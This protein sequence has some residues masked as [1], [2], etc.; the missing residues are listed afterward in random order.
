MDTLLINTLMNI[1]KCEKMLTIF[2]Y[3]ITHYS[4]ITTEKCKTP[5]LYAVQIQ[6]R[7]YLIELYLLSGENHDNCIQQCENIQAE[8]RVQNKRGDIL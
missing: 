3:Y 5:D 8:Y 6:N 2:N 1:L 4:L 7:G